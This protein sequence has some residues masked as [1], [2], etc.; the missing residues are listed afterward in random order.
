MIHLYINK[1]L[2]RALLMLTKRI[3]SK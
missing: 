1:R 3:P 2:A